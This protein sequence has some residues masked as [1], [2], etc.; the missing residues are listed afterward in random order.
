MEALGIAGVTA[1]VMSGLAF[2]SPI[3]AGC[4]GTCLYAGGWPSR[5][6][7]LTTRNTRLCPPETNS[8]PAV[9]KWATPPARSSRFPASRRAARYRQ[10][11]Q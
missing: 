6:A 10:I 8:E 2:L 1:T 3:C 4:I 5:R 9:P 11:L 7:H